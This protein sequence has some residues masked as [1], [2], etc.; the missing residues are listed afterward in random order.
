[1]ISSKAKATISYQYNK[2]NENYI[3]HSECLGYAI[4]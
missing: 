1:M 2:V 3:T 4:Y